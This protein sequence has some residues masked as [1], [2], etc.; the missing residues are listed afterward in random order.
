MSA[1]EDEGSI[2]REF[3]VKAFGGAYIA[4]DDNIF[5]LGYVNSLFALELVTFVERRFGLSVDTDDL[6]LSNFCSVTSIADFVRRKLGS[7]GYVH[8]S[9]EVCQ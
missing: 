8:A 3:L 2:V 1:H 9:E 6:D 4:P 7:P 5:A